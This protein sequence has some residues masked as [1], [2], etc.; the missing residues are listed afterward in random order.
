MAIYNMTGKVDIWWKDINKVKEIKER[1]VTWKTFTNHFKRKHPSE[2]YYEEKAKEFYELRLGAMT[3]K[4]LSSKFSSLLCYVP[5]I[6]DEKPKIQCFLI[7]FPMMFKER[8]QY[9]NLK[10]LEEEM[11]KENL[12]YDQNKNKRESVQI[13]KSKRR[14]HFDP[15]KK[16]NKFHKNTGNNCKWYQGNYHKN[17]KPQ[18]SVVKEREPPTTLNQK[19]A[20]REPLKCWKCGQPHYFK[21]F[22]IRNKNFNVHSIHE[23]VTVGNMARTMPIISA[24]LENRQAHHKKISTHF[25]TN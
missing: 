9:D 20:Q 12:C 17:F 23:A 14:D 21:Y 13:W 1:Y 15:R 22:P 25:Y 3:M 24:V 10:T 19:T 11:R 8:I 4:E 5:Y 6:I 7:F 2:Q 18:N 16:N